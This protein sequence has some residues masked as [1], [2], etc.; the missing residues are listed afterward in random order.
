MLRGW[1]W[2]QWCQQSIARE[3][4]GETVSRVWGAFYWCQAIKWGEGGIEQRLERGGSGMSNAGIGP[5]AGHELVRVGFIGAGDIS[6]LHAAGVAKAKRAELVG[7]WN[8]PGCSIVP[9]PASKV[10]A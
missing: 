6:K 8:R 3:G 4:R 1:C 9:D 10:T 7:L 5:L 2:S